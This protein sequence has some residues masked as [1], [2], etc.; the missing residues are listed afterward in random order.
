MIL[1]EGETGN[2]LF[3]IKEGEVRAYVMDEIGHR[4]VIGIFGP[5]VLLGEGA[6]DGGPRS[7]TVEAIT[8]VT[9]LAVSYVTLKEEMQRDP[10]FAF[11]VV[12]LL[13]AR[14]RHST[15]RIKSL[16]LDTAYRRLRALLGP[17]PSLVVTTQQEIADLIGASR[18]MVTRIFRDLVRGGYIRT[19]KGKVEIVKTLPAN[20]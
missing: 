2:E 8:P 9:A 16:A 6:L 19:T 10:S 7:A 13:I 5:G 11:E 12:M 17:E 4:F 20:W 3:L 18:D 15:A 14:S 1:R